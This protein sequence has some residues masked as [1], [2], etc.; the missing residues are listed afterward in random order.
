MATHLYEALHLALRLWH[1][2]STSGSPIDFLNLYQRALYHAGSVRRA[3]NEVVLEALNVLEI[4]YPQEATL[5]R[6]RFLSDQP[7]HSLVAQYNVG[8]SKLYAMQRR[9]LHLLA[10]VTQERESQLNASHQRV[11][12]SRLPFTTPVPLIGIHQLLEH[13][14]TVLTT[15]GPQWIVALEGIGGIGKTS[16]ADA[17]VRR[18]LVQGVYDDIGWVS[19]QRLSFDDGGLIRIQSDAALSAEMLVRKLGAQLLGDTFLTAPLSAEAALEAVRHRLKTSAHLVVLDN[20]ETL[21]DVDSLLP[22]LHSLAEPSKFL[23]T[24]RYHVVDRHV[25]AFNIPQLS[26]TFAL[27]LIRRESESVSHGT[28]EEVPDE[29][30]HN[31]YATVGGNPLAI[32]LVVGQAVFYGLDAVL[33]DLQE[34][35]GQEV[36]NLYTYIYFHAWEHLDDVARQVFLAMALVSHVGGE[37]RMLTGMLDLPSE[38]IRPALKQLVSLN[39]VDVGGSLMTPRYT[40]HNLTRTFLQKQIAKWYPQPPQ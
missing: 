25:T 9:A 28:L 18:L 10:E 30:L 7:A 27:Q 1:K 3:S 15:R 26:E 16:L 17:L 31:I 6:E 2:P 33:E 21:E 24:S 34:A 35:R 37:I 23:L 39:L 20:L 22:L 14:S 12:E 13:L 19:A 40:I 36:E 11:L 5:L 38:R 29:G 32:R 4:T 8:E